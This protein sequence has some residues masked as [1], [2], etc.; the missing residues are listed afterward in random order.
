[1]LIKDAL[2]VVG[3]LSKPSKM[4]CQGYSIPAE[5]CNVGS[6]LRNIEG[7]VCSKCY[8]MKG[9]YV[10]K[11]VKNALMTRYKKLSHALDNDPSEFRLAFKTLLKKH[12]YFRWHD[13]GDLINERHL[14]M[15]VDIANE[16][17]HCKFWIPTREFKLVTDYFKKHRKP[18]NLIVRLS[19]TKINGKAPRQTA[20][21]YGLTVSEVHSKTTDS[22]ECP[23]YKQDGFCGDCRNCWNP[24]VFNVSYPVH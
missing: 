7:S 17:K 23:A 22:N 20:K 3:G 4:P 9:M 5:L 12:K 6:K 18:K 1:M 10:F 14:Q 13:S 11:N 16:N 2:Q 21:K 8:A 24:K 15:I 19:A